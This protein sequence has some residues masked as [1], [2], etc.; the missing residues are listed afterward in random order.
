MTPISSRRIALVCTALLFNGNAFA[1]SA[2][3]QPLPMPAEIGAPRGAPLDGI[4]RSGYK[5]VYTDKPTDLIKALETAGGGVN[6]TYSLGMTI[7]REGRLTDVVWDGLAFKQGLIAS[8]QIIAI[9]NVV[10]SN[11]HM[12]DAL[13]AA[14]KGAAIELLVKNGDVFR[15][16]RFDYKD[17]A[18]YPKLERVKGTP[19][20]L[21]QILTARK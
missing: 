17:G 19:D 16:V 13:K 15:T 2:P 11:D 9:N 6:L 4:A 10:Y 21:G 18:R 1:Q 3:P 8:T 20:V 5:L 12:K 7:G 14:K